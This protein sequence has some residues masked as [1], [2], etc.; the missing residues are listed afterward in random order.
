MLTIQEGQIVL[1][2]MR[3]TEN[4]EQRKLRPCLVLETTAVSV[5]LVYITSKKLA[6][7]GGTL[8]TEVVL[9]GKEAEAIGLNRDSRVDFAKRDIIPRCEVVK[10]LG[11]LEGLAKH[12]AKAAEMFHA[13]RAAGLLPL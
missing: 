3:F 10:V 2:P 12:K 11:S 13:A 5:T 1:A 6:G 4:T 7:P 8:P 9:R